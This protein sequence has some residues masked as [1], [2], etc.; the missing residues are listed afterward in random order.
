M[1][2]FTIIVLSML[3]AVG[4]QSP[5]AL[6]DT[7]PW[8]DVT[9]RLSGGLPNESAR[10][11]KD[12][13][14]YLGRSADGKWRA[15]AMGYSA[16]FHGT[17]LKPV[18]LYS[19]QDHEGKVIEA[20]EEGE[21]IRLTLQMTIHAD[22]WVT[23]GTARYTLELK[24]DGNA[25]AGTFEGVYTK[26]EST[27]PSHNDG[28]PGDRPCKGR[29]VGAIRADLWPTVV[30][31][32]TPFAPGEHPRMIFRK[33]DLPE[34]RRRAQTPQG[35]AILARLER[36]LAEKE[37]LWHGYG[38]GL[39]YQLT[40][41]AKWA[42]AAKKNAVA[43]IEG[44]VAAGKYGWYTRNGGYLRA[45]PSVAATAAV[46]DLCYD[47]WDPEFRQWVAK[48]IQDRIWPA[49]ALEYDQKESDGQLSP[50]SNHYMNWNG[51]A[52]FAML[53]IK[54]DPGT[55]PDISA[56]ADRLF[57]QRLKRGLEVG[58]GD[59][60]FFWE[61]T[62]CG[63]FPTNGGLAMYIQALRV[64]QGKD[65]VANSSPAQ[66]LTSKW[67]FEVLRNGGKLDIFMRGMYA[68]GFDLEGDSSGG[69]FAHGFGILPEAH[70]PAVLAFYN[71]I[72]E[73]AG[74]NT[75]DA[76]GPKQAV[77]ALV[78][79]PIGMKE[80]EPADV[81][82]HVLH[83]EAAGFYVFRS[84]WKGEG[85]IVVSMWG[86]TVV[87][88]MGIK[89]RFAAGLPIAVRPFHFDK[90]ADN[91]FTVSARSQEEDG[92]IVAMAVDF[93]GKA[94]TPALVVAVTAR[95]AQRAQTPEEA[96]RMEALR[97]AL[98]ADMNKPSAEAPARPNVAANPKA[99]TTQ[100]AAGGLTYSIFCI[101]A[102]EPVKFEVLGDAQEQKV[103][104]AGRTFWF[105]GQ[106]IVLE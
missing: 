61:G 18:S 93:S 49:M 105:D 83:D 20:V 86:N 41:D 89:A 5:N 38:Y 91:A 40:G 69:D 22:P 47:G 71:R 97:R 46:Y 31:G 21:T 92:K 75:Y 27:R 19:W 60:G 85:D 87:M 45:G 50:R 88:G 104:A 15:D 106:K 9:L 64:A 98:G 53:A 36:M 37:S 81:F 26:A 6:A 52:G 78:N 59:H 79:W 34:L 76:L 13:E 58:F 33:G 12:I 24:R 35:K 14:V 55:D 43:A 73:L 4:V 63:R 99:R 62:F 51:G 54:D 1:R 94:G 16:F 95:E 23:G 39:M 32:I 72:I 11:G 42:E 84:G 80:Q 103:R 28:P 2:I 48:K 101:D 90:R 74:D 82:G 57:Q 77:Y 10:L 102:G 56:R 17:H 7:G 8:H 29:V 66:W 67:A 100:I 44:K 25:L 70:K 30:E 65:Y 68:R 3:F 96:A